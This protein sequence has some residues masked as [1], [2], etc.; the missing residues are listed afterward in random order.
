MRRAFTL[1]ELLV[2]IAI[3]GVLIALLLPAVQAAREA[4]RRAQCSN[5]L[6]QIGI[7]LHNYHDV[8]RQMPIGAVSVPPPFYG[9]PE[10]VYF[11]HQLLPYVEQRAAAE[12]L[13][14]IMLTGV[15]PWYGGAGAVWRPMD[16]VFIPTYLCP[17]D[18]YGENWSNCGETHPFKV[19]Y[20][21]FWPGQNE[22]DAYLD[23]VD[24]GNLLVRTVFRQNRGAS[25][26]EMLDGSSNVM[27]IGEYLKGTS[28]DVF[29]GCPITH[30]A[31]CQFLFVGLGPNDPLPD[32]SLPLAGFC[33]AA[34]NQPTL[35]LP[36]I[37][38]WD[39]TNTAASRSRHPGGVNVLMGD[40]SARFTASTIDKTTWR[41]MAYMANGVTPQ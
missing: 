40:A 33:T 6:H 21:G 20:L 31:C 22:Q 9:S 4:A 24:R 27:V 19:N 30:R 32:I 23:A 26:A 11:L 2:V 17:S 12:K 37:G 7:G 1:V 8:H 28:A 3:I 13:Q 14:A 15:R 41:S 38:I 5:N 10:W 39:Y 34:E 29:F 16:K 25:F 35:N 18:G 36:C